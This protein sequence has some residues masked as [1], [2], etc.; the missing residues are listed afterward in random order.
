MPTEIYFEHLNEIYTT[1]SSIGSHYIEE[2]D[3]FFPIRHVMPMLHH[4]YRG[5]E[6]FLSGLFVFREVYSS[7]GDIHEYIGD[8]K[9]PE[10]FQSY[11]VNNIYREIDDSLV[12]EYGFEGVSDSPPAWVDW[13]IKARAFEFHAETQRARWFK[14]FRQG[15]K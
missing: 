13:T 1:D 11:A 14:W 8:P 5:K 6:F 10:G 4:P 2:N 15:H 3:L 9:K 7:F 12:I